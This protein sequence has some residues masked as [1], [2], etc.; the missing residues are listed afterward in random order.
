MKQ[1]RT[2]LLPM[3]GLLAI[4][5]G[6]LSPTPIIAQTAID[7]FL[8]SDQYKSFTEPAIKKNRKK[9]APE[10]LRIIE[11]EYLSLF[12]KGRDGGKKLIE[13]LGNSSTRFR[14]SGAKGKNSAQFITGETEFHI[15]G[16]EK[17]ASVPL[18]VLLPKPKAYISQSYLILADFAELQP[19]KLKIDNSQEVSGIFGNG[20]LY[21]HK[22]GDCSLVIPLSKG[23][24]LNMGPVNC[25][26]NEKMTELANAIDVARVNRKINEE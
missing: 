18:M 13:W 21:F 23:G 1:L 25:E 20:K 16:A 5:N 11:S 15:V 10:D 14:R 9:K 7:D 26:L 3:V 24:L 4:L 22:G 19:P 8:E 2:L 17:R 6:A 12:A